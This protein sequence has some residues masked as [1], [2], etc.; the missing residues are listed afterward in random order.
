MSKGKKGSGS[1]DWVK[2][3][4]TRS[5]FFVIPQNKYEVAVAIELQCKL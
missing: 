3:G 4:S 2:E 5:Y 1:I